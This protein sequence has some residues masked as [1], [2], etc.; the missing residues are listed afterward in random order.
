MTN[1]DMATMATSALS[2]VGETIACTVCE[3]PVSVTKT[4]VR[5]MFGH[6]FDI[7]RQGYVSMLRPTSATT[8]DDAGMVLARERMLAVGFYEPLA[9]ALCAMVAELLGTNAAR[10]AQPLVVDA[11]GGTGYV[12]AALLARINNAR[13]VTLDLSRPASQRAARQH[14]R[15]AAIRCDIWQRWPLQD[16]C[17]Q[18]VLHVLAPRNAAEA[19]RVLDHDGTL[20]VVSPT[21][22]HL[23]EVVETLGLIQIDP[24]KQRRLDDD[25]RGMFTQQHVDTIE[26]TLSLTPSE[27][28]DVVAMGPSAAHP[29]I[30]QALNL[31]MPTSSTSVTFSLR[32]HVF[33]RLS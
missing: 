3:R 16:D 19:H 24:H 31:H 27:I 26:T 9:G 33:R 1:H 4:S 23:Q 25:M 21:D 22:R 10:A 28:R 14:S 2:L 12:S 29:R 15:M 17:A 6:T 13:A 20:V 11:G 30:G 5:C 8:D 7:A 32:V 18:L